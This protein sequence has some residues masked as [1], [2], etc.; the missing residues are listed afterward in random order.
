M[1]SAV[2]LDPLSTFEKSGAPSAVSATLVVLLP[3]FTFQKSVIAASLERR[4]PC[5]A[6][7]GMASVRDSTQDEYG[8]FHPKRTSSGNP[9]SGD[10]WN[11][12]YGI[13]RQPRRAQT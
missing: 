8:A 2:E 3:L 1:R 11:V 7:R 5:C 6:L 10:P 13:T 4:N 12:R 9:A